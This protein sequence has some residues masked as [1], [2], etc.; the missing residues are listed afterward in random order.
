MLFYLAIQPQPLIAF[1][2][3]FQRLKRLTILN[4]RTKQ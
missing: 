2:S 3:L 4:Y 1:A